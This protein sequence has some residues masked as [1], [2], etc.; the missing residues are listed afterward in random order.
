MRMIPAAGINLFQLIYILIREYEAKA[1][2]KC[3][4]LSLG[5]PDLIPP[6]EVLERKSRFAAKTDY[7][8]HTYAEDKNLERFAEG[9]VEA[10]SGVRLEDIVSFACVC[11]RRVRHCLWRRL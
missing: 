3:L 4:N 5:N 11:C 8:L 10:F 2:K 9:M 7:D 1:G 6:S